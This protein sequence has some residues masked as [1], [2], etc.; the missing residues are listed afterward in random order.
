MSKRFNSKSLFFNLVYDYDELNRDISLYENS[1]NLQ[2]HSYS[3]EC[4]V[5]PFT[6]QT[7]KGSEF[8]KY[9]PWFKKWCKY[10]AENILEVEEVDSLPKLPPWDME[11]IA[12][13]DDYELD[14]SFKMSSLKAT[15]TTD[16]DIK[17]GEKRFPADSKHIHSEIDKWVDSKIFG[18]EENKSF[19]SMKSTS[20]LSPYITSGSISTREVIASIQKKHKMEVLNSGDSSVVDYV[21]EIAWRD[22]YKH[23]LAANP[24]LQFDLPY[25]FNTLD[26]NRENGE[27]NFKKWCL[28]ETGY[29]IIDASMRQLLH[30]GWINNRCRMI[31]CTFLTKDLLVDWR[32]GM[33][34]FHHR[35]IDGEYSSN[36]GGWT[37]CSS[38]GIDCQPWFRIF[39]TEK[40]SRAY[41]KD[42]K[43]IK[44]WVPELKNCDPKELH[45]LEDYEGYPKPIPLLSR[46]EKMERLKEAQ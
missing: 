24:F 19:P 6:L 44:K 1:E 11:Q 42:G 30:T 43:F 31:V 16:S 22:F 32:W 4:I 8:K 3:D 14:S 18:Y 10:L 28:G 38:S 36:H 17:E 12:S 2:I 26:L 23:A 20:I 29:P 21:M 25:N 39:S 15:G 13:D 27:E 9:S 37:W 33:N 41:D 35:L 45:T 46:D 7:G 34:W 40:Q 5:K